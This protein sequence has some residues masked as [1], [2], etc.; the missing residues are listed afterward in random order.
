MKTY[1][2][3]G[4]NVSI[5]NDTLHI[6]SALFIKESCKFSDIESLEFIEP[7]LLENGY[8]QI[9]T[10]KHH[11]TIFFLKKSVICLWNYMN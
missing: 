10:P 6:K 1:K 7:T 9:K 3:Y 4:G 2:G 5:D 8:I 11:H